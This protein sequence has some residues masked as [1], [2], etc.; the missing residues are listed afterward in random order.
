MDVIKG[1]PTAGLTYNPN[2]EVYWDQPA[3]KGEIDRVYNMLKQEYAGLVGTEAA[4]RVG[5]ATMDLTE[6]LFERK[7]EGK[8]NRD[9]KSRR[10]RWAIIYHVI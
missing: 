4:K 3:L 1:K 7:K 8:F 2:D 6:Y 10:A 9:F 5:A